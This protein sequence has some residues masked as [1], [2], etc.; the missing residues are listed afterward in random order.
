MFSLLAGLTALTSIG[1][2]NVDAIYCANCK[3]LLAVSFETLGD[4]VSN[5]WYCGS[6]AAAI[7]CIADTIGIVT[8]KPGYA[9]GLPNVPS[10]QDVINLE[11]LD[12]YR[13]QLTFATTTTD[14]CRDQRQKSAEEKVSK[15][16]T[17]R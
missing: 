17:E 6:C 8:G 16:L 11:T 15:L 3:T 14:W 2:T 4:S 9:C 7:G 10:E 12:N 5:I 13:V 1:Y